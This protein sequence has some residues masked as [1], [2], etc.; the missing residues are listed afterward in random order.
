MNKYVTKHTINEVKKYIEINNV[1]LYQW[2]ELTVSHIASTCDFAIIPINA[3]DPMD[4]GKPEDKLLIFWLMGLPTV[5]SET[6]AHLMAMSAAGL[7]MSCASTNDWVSAIR[8]LADNASS[9]N[10]AAK[11]GFMYAS[12]V[13]NEEKMMSSWD[14][15]F[16]FVV[17]MKINKLA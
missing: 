13:S 9:R 4:N 15:M 7:S 8:N 10:Q 3:K 5:V 12:D 17:D 16:N 11:K 2:N 6:P 14:N 1:H